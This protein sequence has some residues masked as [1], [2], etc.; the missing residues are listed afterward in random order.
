[1]PDTNVTDSPV[2]VGNEQ[3]ESRTSTGNCA[4]HSSV[5]N[6]R[7]TK[8]SHNKKLLKS[9]EA[10]RAKTYG[11]VPHSDS[12]TKCDEEG[13]LI[14]PEECPNE[15]VAKNSKMAADDTVTNAAD[16]PVRKQECDELGCGL[17]LG[18]AVRKSV[19]ADCGKVQGGSVE[20]ISGIEVAT[21]SQSI[22]EAKVMMKNFVT[23]S[24]NN[25]GKTMTSTSCPSEHEG[26]LKTTNTFT[27]GGCPGTVGT[28]ASVLTE[29]SKVK[30]KRNRCDRKLKPSSV[31]DGV[32]RSS[33]V[34]KCANS[35]ST[36]DMSLGK[37]RTR[38]SINTQK[39][40]PD[41]PHRSL[42]VGM[43]SLKP[44]RPEQVDLTK[45]GKD[46]S[47]KPGAKRLH[48]NSP[49]E[50]FD[51]R[52]GM[53]NEM[54]TGP[55]C[56]GHSAEADQ[57][58]EKQTMEHSAKSCDDS[59]FV[60]LT[61][62]I[63]Q[64]S[65]PIERDS[66]TFK[67]VTSHQKNSD[68]AV[69]TDAKHFMDGDS[70]ARTTNNGVFKA[71]LNS[72][73]SVVRSNGKRRGNIDKQTKTNHRMTPTNQSTESLSRMASKS[74]TDIDE[75][76][77]IINEDGTIHVK[78]ESTTKVYGRSPDKK[79]S[80]E[81]V[82]TS[83]SEKVSPL[84]EASP[85][86]VTVAQQPDPERSN[87][88]ADGIASIEESFQNSGRGKRKRMP[89]RYFNFGGEVVWWEVP[90]AF[91]RKRLNR[92]TVGNNGETVNRKAPRIRRVRKTSV[93]ALR[94]Q[95][96]DAVNRV[97]LQ[98]V[99]KTTKN[100]VLRELPMRKSDATAVDDELPLSVFCKKKP[101]ATVLPLNSVHSDVSPKCV[102]QKQMKQLKEEDLARGV[103][104]TCVDIVTLMTEDAPL[105][106][107]YCGID[108]D[109]DDLE[110]E[111]VEEEEYVF[112]PDTCQTLDLFVPDSLDTGSSDRSGGAEIIDC[113]SDSQ[114]PRSVAPLADE[115]LDDET[116]Q[117]PERSNSAIYIISSD[118][119]TD[120]ATPRATNDDK[121][122]RT[123]DDPTCA[124]AGEIVK[125]AVT[126]KVKARCKA[127][128]SRGSTRRKKKS[129][130]SAGF[131]YDDDS[132]D[133]RLKN[134]LT[135]TVKV[136]QSG[137]GVRSGNRDSIT[138]GPHQGPYVRLEGCRE[139]PTSCT[140]VSLAADELEKTTK[141]HTG[142][143]QKSHKHSAPAANLSYK[144]IDSE[145]FIC[146]FCANGSCYETLNDLFGP[147]HPEGAMEQHDAA[148]VPKRR[149]SDDLPAE[150]WVHEDCAVWASG[151]YLVGS[152][153]HGLD[154]AVSVARQTVRVHTSSFPP[155]MWS[156]CPRLISS[157]Q[158][159]FAS[160]PLS[161]PSPSRPH[162]LCP[163]TPT[164]VF[165][166]LSPLHIHLHHSYSSLYMSCSHNF[167]PLS[168]TFLDIA[169]TFFVPLIL[170]H[171]Y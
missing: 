73:R 136:S 164:S 162:L 110:V 25:K 121:D 69:S 159:G 135:K 128:L 90:T 167:N 143:S 163:S 87:K 157:T 1:M 161:V 13:A 76:S 42:L 148:G 109:L 35:L 111:E 62:K 122:N 80:V 15:N 3:A 134:H 50:S 156:R 117:P 92:P 48:K 51:T 12:P 119:E 140:V 31:I 169:P 151:V 52:E 160:P 112:C 75:E 102:T 83:P 137:K 142:K 33:G 171:S 155:S 46:V 14:E 124:D 4:S 170:S 113:D 85:S 24:A 10:C 98:D 96:A 100:G 116:S 37:E 57:G 70:L 55:G 103:P 45:I 6:C 59:K 19:A 22:D 11:C 141:Q 130:R 147:Y 72:E 68:S 91:K 93:G 154:E 99:G 27:N 89:N 36:T 53:L 129:K 127:R 120:V 8:K 126:N 114:K 158:P 26:K 2:C 125:G 138:V 67:T 153:L 88:L 49:A 101:V 123:G 146:A 82:S 166:S 54:Y 105:E 152:K 21:S 9:T 32:V 165:L 106:G 94:K 18:D 44:M 79:N 43:S 61:R 107:S 20:R 133:E 95:K 34:V 108:S 41:S 97:L 86:D 104:P 139:T 38:L 23:S 77:A 118:E 74:S 64:K 168:C 28:T 144:L 7:T 47:G 17:E 115:E 29:A 131:D 84:K 39:S 78:R 81:A 40:S 60:C 71:N 56:D 149:A 145:P 16:E 132:A 5:N 66:G 30:K 65:E 150:M 58:T 63:Y